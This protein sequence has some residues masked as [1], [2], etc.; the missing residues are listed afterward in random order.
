MSLESRSRI[1]QNVQKIIRTYPKKSLRIPN[2]SGKVQISPKS[3]NFVFKICLESLL[4]QTVCFFSVDAWKIQ[5]WHM[6]YKVESCFLLYTLAPE[7]ALA[8]LIMQ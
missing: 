3:K 2:T 6:I 1:G 4:K 8:K 7:I 5:V